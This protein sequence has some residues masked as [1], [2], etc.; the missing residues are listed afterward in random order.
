MRRMNGLTYVIQPKIDAIQSATGASHA[1]EYSSLYLKQELTDEKLNSID[2][3]IMRKQNIRELKFQH[4]IS[5]GG[6]LFS[7]VF[8]LPSIYQT[9]VL[10]RSAVLFIYSGDIP[11]ISITCVSII[12]W[13]I[14][15]CVILKKQIDYL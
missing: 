8:G 9:L 15:I 5:I 13:V 10:L 11:F 3:M 7:L 4:Y 14:L 6:F 12:L 2:E 1:R